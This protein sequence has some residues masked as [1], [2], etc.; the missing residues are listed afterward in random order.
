MAVR[1]TEEVLL[2]CKVL[3]DSS[4]TYQTASWYKVRK[5]P[6][7]LKQSALLSY[8]IL[9][10]LV[11]NGLFY[12]EASSCQCSRDK[13]A[14]KAFELITENR[15][16]PCH[17]RQTIWVWSLN[18]SW[19]AF[20][21]SYCWFPRI[22]IQVMPHAQPAKYYSKEESFQDFSSEQKMVF[23]PCNNNG[24]VPWLISPQTGADFFFEIEELNK[25]LLFFRKMWLVGMGLRA[26]VC[27]RQVES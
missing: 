9:A 10:C 23:K 26:R 7:L 4:I 15:H 27:R 3:R 19:P 22:R 14:M 17:C 1:C 5:K 13:A 16:F 6:K 21:S 25:Y 11:K 24:V 20:L 2:P 18:C 8:P 12:G